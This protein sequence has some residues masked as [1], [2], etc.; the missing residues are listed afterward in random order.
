VVEDFLRNHVEIG[1]RSMQPTPL[2]QAYVRFNYMHERDH[3]I[4]NSPHLFSNGTISF[5][6]HNRA[7]N[8]RSAMMTHEVWIM[9]LGL[10]LDLWT[11]PLVDKAVSSFGRLL[12]WEEDHHNQARAMVKVRVAAL[13]E[14]PWFFVFTDGVG[15][16][17]DSWTVQCEILQTDILGAAPQDEDFAPDDDDFDPNHFAY[18]GFGQ[19]GPGA[20]QPPPPE[21]PPAQPNPEFQNAVGWGLWPVEDAA[22]L[23]NVDDIPDL[24]PIQQEENFEDQGIPAPVAIQ[25]I[26]PAVEEIDIQHIPEVEEVLAMAESTEELEDAHLSA[27]SPEESVNMAISPTLQI[28][29]Q[30]PSQEED[31]D[32]DEI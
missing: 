18:N 16:E 19:L 10:N 14:I 32:D 20:P 8:N 29:P 15:F 13:D 31:Q 4:H 21:D 11:Q 12:I 30:A 23:E 9:M 5:I 7:W 27:P 24:V 1:F 2:G 25:E 3:L 17:S 6:P 28:I 26:L 22:D